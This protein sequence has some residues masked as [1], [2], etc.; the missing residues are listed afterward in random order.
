MEIFS[1]TWQAASFLHRQIATLT[2]ASEPIYQPILLYK[3]FTD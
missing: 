2:E 3:N 1:K